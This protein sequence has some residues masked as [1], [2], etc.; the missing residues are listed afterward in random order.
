MSAPSATVSQTDF[1]DA[2]S[3]VNVTSEPN[4]GFDTPI[5]TYRF[6]DETMDT[7]KSVST[8]LQGLASK[9]GNPRKRRRD[10]SPS[11]RNPQE[12]YVDTRDNYPKESK[13]IYLRLK[14]LY[15]KKVS[16]ASTIKTMETK[17][18]KNC[19]PT[20]VDFRFNINS[21]R[22]PVLRDSWA[23]AVRKCKTDMTLALLDDLQKTYNNTRSQ[24][25]K[26]MADL[27]KL[28][29]PEQLQEIKDISNWPLSLWKR[30]NSNIELRRPHKDRKT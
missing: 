12:P 29:N 11:R 28:L 30:S 6:S 5:P 10:G 26:D 17:L 27:E 16:L 9:T 20:S 13:V 15:R 4:S 18:S 7:L 1:C 21:T 8:K 23:R 24:I 3:R 14:T 25:T 2:M 22:N 19:F